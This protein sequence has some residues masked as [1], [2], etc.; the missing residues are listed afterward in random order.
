MNELTQEER[1]EAANHADDLDRAA[2]FLRRHSDPNSWE[3]RKTV[4]VPLTMNQTDLVL[5]LID[6]E[7]TYQKRSDRPYTVQALSDLKRQIKDR[8]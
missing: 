6:T 4:Y 7:L 1:E 2:R 5:S 3:A 8:L